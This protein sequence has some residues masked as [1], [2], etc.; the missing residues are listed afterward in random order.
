MAL[1]KT[2][3]ALRDTALQNAKD[4]THPGLSDICSGKAVAYQHILDLLAKGTVMSVSHL[5]IVDCGIHDASYRSNEDLVA[6][7][8]TNEDYVAAMLVI[9]Q[10]SYPDRR[11][12][13]EPAD[14]V[15]FSHVPTGPGPFGTGHDNSE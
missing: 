12:K 11:F 15:L 3:I 7:N 9:L 1:I 10:T 13:A 2:L 14:Y 8:I 4:I 6:E 5:K